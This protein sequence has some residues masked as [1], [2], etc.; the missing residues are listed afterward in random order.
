MQPSTKPRPYRW[1][2]INVNAPKPEPEDPPKPDPWWLAQ[3]KLHPFKI[4]SLVLLTM[5]GLMLLVFFLHLGEMAEVNLAGSTSLLAAVALI[6]T[7]VV[8]FLGGT[9]IAIGLMYRGLPDEAH[10]VRSVTA[11]LCS[12]IPSL[13]IFVAAAIEQVWG[14]RLVQPNAW[15][16]VALGL[17]TAISTGLLIYFAVVGRIA[18]A[19]LS[20]WKAFGRLVL[21]FALIWFFGAMWTTVGAATTALSLLALM[22]P[23]ESA[24]TAA[25][26][27]L[28]WN[29][30]CI[31]TNVALA[32]VPK[33]KEAFATVFLVGIGFLL[34]TILSRNLAGVPIA[35]VRALGLGDFPARLVVTAT[36][37]EIVNNAAGQKVCSVPDGERT[38]VICPV[39]VRS[40]I[41]TPFLVQLSPWSED[42]EWPSMSAPPQ[43]PIPRSE[44]LS[45]PHIVA[46][47]KA[48]AKAAEP[49]PSAQIASAS[50][51]ASASSSTAEPPSLRASAPAIAQRQSVVSHLE[52]DT[53]DPHRQGWLNVQCGKV[54]GH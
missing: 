6:G 18:L 44:V 9:A 11:M 34:L 16:K 2:P 31:A 3:L 49:S 4:G 28:A 8:L 39:I 5:G 19:G 14:Y 12:A 51:P 13:A 26:S 41:G 45:W 52:S 29:L 33:K 32:S 1:P 25:K 27:L 48:K 43:I 7:L 36:G 22:A 10:P 46:F 21:T 30:F 35:A 23:S 47:K 42:L 17:S 20:F 38:G 50:A 24:D 54:A 15:V 40:A 53:L 37:C